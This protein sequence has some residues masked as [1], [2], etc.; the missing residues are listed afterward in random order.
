MKGKL[1]R[2]ALGA[3]VFFGLLGCGVTDTV[4]NNVVG[5]SKGNSVANLW[6]DVPPMPGSQKL[7]LDLPVTVQLGIQALMKTSASS[8][9]VSLD[10]FD[11]IAYSTPQ[12]I[13]Q[14][15]AYYTKER[16]TALGW[17]ATDQP[18]CNTGADTSGLAGGVC[19]FAKGKATA[20][21]KGAVLFVV[22]AQDDKTKQTQVY[23][24]RLEGVITKT[25]TK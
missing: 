22:L 13:D 25:P 17:N 8:S 6:S 1:Q 15:S 14:V 24:V 16:M 2:V 12:T 7:A 18:G 3:L 23:Y 5:G 4:L 10:T 21:D 11:W 20:N 19:L 9:D